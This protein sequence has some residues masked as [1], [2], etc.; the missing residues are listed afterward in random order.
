[1]EKDLTSRLGNFSR[2]TSG[3]IAKNSEAFGDNDYLVYRRTSNR[4][5]KNYTLEEIDNII[6]SGSLDEQRKLSRNYFQKDG[7]YR[8]IITYYTNLL[9]NCGI[10]I[11]QTKA[12]QKLTSGGTKKKYYGALDYIEKINPKILY[13]RIY[14][15][16]LIDGA[17]YGVIQVLD[18]NDFILLDLPAAYSISR[19][20]DFYGRDLIE[21]DVSYFNTILEKELREEVL[22]A[23]PKEISAYYR[24]WNR[25]KVSSPW[26]RLP[27]EL[28]IYFSF[29]EEGAP[30]FLN[31]IPA[32]I[33]YDEAVDTERERDL[34]EIRKILVQKVPHLTDGSLLFE[35]EEALEM[36]RGAVGM[37]KGN[38]NLSVLTTY[39]DVDAIVSK[40]SSDT[41]SN[42]LEKML[43]NVYSE[44]GVSGQIFAP[45]G[46]QSLSISILNDIS[47]MMPLANKISHVLSEILNQL[48]GNS[49][50]Q[51]KYT[52]LPVSVYNQSDYL[53]DAFKL[54]QSG[55]SFYLPAVT[56]DLSQRDLM[57]MKEL[58]NDLD[59]L[60]DKLIPLGSAYT[61][62]ASAG[63]SN[64]GGR[65]AMK[66]EDKAETTIQQEI[67][68]DKGG[69]SNEN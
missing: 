68:K 57:G 44:A 63:A 55:Y 11:P 54:A 32:T 10:L 21:F 20:K 17:Y 65:P 36:H 45:T 48:F 12:G 64:E 53:T 58:E 18:K 60:Q 59:K 51:F 4:K 25:G 43:Q 15:R 56:M 16:C 7:L 29:L 3:M 35:P 22:A 52:T 5:L 31:V 30:I 62:S 47:L 38:K 37:L 26:V 49:N 66:V 46:S 50:I 9:K 1:M 27:A 14:S 67:S 8:A 39:T 6:N 34:E 42:N 41:V 19:F 40:T 24:K 28:G 2:A 13:N 69:V 23:Y 61:Q 33:Q